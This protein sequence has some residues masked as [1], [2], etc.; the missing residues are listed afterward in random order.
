MSTLT[1]SRNQLLAVSLT[2]VALTFAGCSSLTSMKSK[3]DQAAAEKLL[4]EQTGKTSEEMKYQ[5]DNGGQEYP[6]GTAPTD[7]SD[8]TSGDKVMARVR[9]YIAVPTWFTTDAQSGVA[10]NDY[11]SKVTIYGSI[12]STKS[13]AE[14]KDFWTGYFTSAGYTGVTQT[15][16]GSSFIIS[17]KKGT[18]TKLSVTVSNKSPVSMSITYNGTK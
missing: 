9:Q 4:Q 18:D 2:A 14:T 11:T 6:A 16:N 13:Y 12:V 3:S 7:G 17:G 15:D 8:Q 5:R 1:I 10:L